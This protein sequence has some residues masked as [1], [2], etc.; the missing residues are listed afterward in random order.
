LT[1]NIMLPDEM[2]NFFPHRI[3][4]NFRSIVIVA[5]GYRLLSE[6]LR[7]LTQQT[8]K[9]IFGQHFIWKKRGT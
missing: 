2:V 7:I 9:L 5:C 8:V 6:D 3:Y 1:D 4:D